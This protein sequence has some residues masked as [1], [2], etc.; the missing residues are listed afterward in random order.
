MNILTKLS[1]TALAVATLAGCASAPLE[2]PKTE[3][4]RVASG[5][6]L[7][8]PV[9]INLTDFT[10]HKVTVSME[11]GVGL[12]DFK[13]SGQV[14][15]FTDK[16]SGKTYDFEGQPVSAE[17]HRIL[18]N[19]YVCKPKLIIN[20]LMTKTIY[21]GDRNAF[22]NSDSIQDCGTFKQVS[23]RV[24]GNNK[25][26]YVAPALLSGPA[27]IAALGYLATTD[28]DTA[29]QKQEIEEIIKDDINS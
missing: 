21:Y 19:G 27:S 14:T 22:N 3:A 28:N 29:K 26:M 4:E 25:P 1:L 20:N 5:S 23:R 24:N 11:K 9:A 6:L 8:V 12:W 16:K 13:N 7:H 2:P 10:W 18:T 15:I 17:G